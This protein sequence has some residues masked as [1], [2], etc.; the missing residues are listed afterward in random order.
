[1]TAPALPR[2]EARRSPWPLWLDFAAPWLVVTLLASTSTGLGSAVGTWWLFLGWRFA[3]VPASRPLTAFVGAFTLYGT[4][5]WLAASRFDLVYP[6]G[7][8]E[9]TIEA[10]TRL[11]LFALVATFVMLRVLPL[12]LSM[13]WLRCA[14]LE[15]L[16]RASR[17]GGSRLALI[18]LGLATIALRDWWQL[19]AIGLGAVFEADRRAYAGALLTASNHNVQIAVM[20]GTIA[21]GTA[22]VA[23]PERRRRAFVLAALVAMTWGPSLLVGARKSPLIVLVA[24]ALLALAAGRGRIAPRGALLAAAGLAVGLLL[25]PLASTGRLDQASIEFVYPQYVLFA[26]ME[27]DIDLDYGY[28]RG[29]TLMLP[30]A[31][32]PFEVHDIGSSFAD[33]GVTNV[34]VGAHPVGEAYLASPGAAGVLAVAATVLVV[35]AVRLLARLDPAFAVA[36]AAHLVLWGRSDLWITL[37]FSMY[38]GAL[39]WL[40]LARPRRASVLERPA[41]EAGTSALS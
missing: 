35:L 23:R 8:T 12:D 24:L 37:F 9:A 22:A 27:H 16:D 5:A 25:I 13:T 15:L 36:G 28:G 18:A 33:L 19:R 20:A 29:A 34:G 30:A 2:I 41:P 21:L 11:T 3:A 7:P 14:S 32:R 4:S 6:P 39:L 17:L 40:L 1:M 26:A 10:G 31:L 38:V